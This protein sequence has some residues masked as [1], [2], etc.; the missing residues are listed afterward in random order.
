M[1]KKLI[2]LMHLSVLLAINVF[3]DP[4]SYV[5]GFMSVAESGQLPRGLFAKVKGYLPGDTISMTN[6]ESGL[7]VDVL[8]LASLD[9]SVENTILLSSE[10][11]S[12]LGLDS[13]MPVAV[14]LSKR[15]G[16]YDKSSRGAA[17]LASYN[18]GSSGTDI[19]DY[20]G[21]MT[22]G[23]SDGFVKDKSDVEQPSPLERA[24]SGISSGG[25]GGSGQ[26]TSVD[27]ASNGKDE[28]A[29]S[30]DEGQAVSGKESDRTP[31]VKKEDPLEEVVE[32]DDLE[33]LSDDFPFDDEKHDE[34][35]PEKS[36]DEKEPDAVVPV[37]SAEETEED[38]P[39]KMRTTALNQSMKS[40]L[41]KLTT[42]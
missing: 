4:A 36:G 39:R 19:A 1:I 15:S 14:R 41:K 18:G 24:E 17:L 38:E 3:A 32:P 12:K 13:G 33:G 11:A 31:A 34:P 25:S 26:K 22:P 8:N 28:S 29:S 30:K 9:S 6:S 37:E 20:F 7:T 10:A 23:D 42:A 27:S 5:D 21:N 35:V 2:L 40:L 16:S